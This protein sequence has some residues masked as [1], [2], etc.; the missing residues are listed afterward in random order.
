MII[1][2]SGWDRRRINSPKQKNKYR[3]LQTLTETGVRTYTDLEMIFRKP[4]THRMG[5]VPMWWSSPTHD[6]LE[7]CLLFQ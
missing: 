7:N 3:S 4:Y 5:C 1:L 6:A 2:P